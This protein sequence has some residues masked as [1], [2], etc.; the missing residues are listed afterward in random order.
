LQVAVALY[1]LEAGA[2]LVMSPW[3]RLWNETVVGRSPLLLQPLLASSFFRGFVAG[4]GLLHLAV[5]AR[6]IDGWRRERLARRSSTEIRI[7]TR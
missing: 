7:P 1:F 4:L 5:A 3:S 2:F 6:E